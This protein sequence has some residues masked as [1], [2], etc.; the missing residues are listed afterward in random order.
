MD[1][2]P[3]QIGKKG[4]KFGQKNFIAKKGKKFEQNRGE[5]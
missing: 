3:T 2:L 5:S 1:F 4:K